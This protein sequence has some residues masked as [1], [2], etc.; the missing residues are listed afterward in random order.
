MLAA[1]LKDVLL[2][3]D[4]YQRFGPQAT[5]RN[6]RRSAAARRDQAGVARGCCRR[7][8]ESGLR[9]ARIDR[10]VSV[11]C[12]RCRRNRVGAQFTETPFIAGDG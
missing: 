4:A 12:R 7:G 5:R 3:A 10:P 9:E 8:A 11:V 6:G 1:P 2:H